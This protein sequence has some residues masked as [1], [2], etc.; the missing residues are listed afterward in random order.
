MDDATRECLLI[1]VECSLPAERLIAALD[2]LWADRHCITL[3]F[4]ES[5]SPVHNA[6]IESFDGRFRDQS[7]NEHW[8]LDLADAMATIDALRLGNNTAPP[9]GNCQE[10]CQTNTSRTCRIS[11]TLCI[12]D[13]PSVN[14]R[15]DYQLGSRQ[16]KSL[17]TA[18]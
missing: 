15:E 5:G 6:F 10:E 16:G 18:R 4:I 12:L 1:E 11:Y 2:Q 14:S 3:A 13:Q 9:H 17:G 8:F 7:L